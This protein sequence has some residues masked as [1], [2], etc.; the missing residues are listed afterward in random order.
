MSRVREA[1]IDETKFAEA[2][3]KWGFAGKR[4]WQKLSEYLTIFRKDRQNKTKIFRVKI[5][6][7]TLWKFLKLRDIFRSSRRIDRARRYEDVFPVECVDEWP[8][9]RSKAPA[10][11]FQLDRIRGKALHDDLRARR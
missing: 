9:E 5:E 1:R 7:G 8:H 2:R 10:L 11:I 6:E 4:P 3:Q